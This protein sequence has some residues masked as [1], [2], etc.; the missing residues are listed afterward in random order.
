MLYAEY[1]G[2][3][4]RETPEDETEDEHL[5]FIRWYVLKHSLNTNASS[6]RILLFNP[7][8]RRWWYYSPWHSLSEI[9]AMRQSLGLELYRP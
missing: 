3:D 9:N 4:D 1:W 7:D 6:G 8:G 2:Y 5:Y